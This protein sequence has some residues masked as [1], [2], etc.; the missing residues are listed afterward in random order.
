[1]ITRVPTIDQSDMD[2]VYGEEAVRGLKHDITRT[3]GNLQEV[4]AKPEESKQ[5]CLRRSARL[6][7]ESSEDEELL[8]DA[9][10]KVSRY[11]QSFQNLIT[12]F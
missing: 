10:T 5:K 9:V 3:I 11:L 4:V 12:T 2:F 1:M 6:S 7:Q 8:L